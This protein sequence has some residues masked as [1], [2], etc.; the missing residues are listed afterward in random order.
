MTRKQTLTVVLRRPNKNVPWGISIA[1][2]S[3]LG[4]PLIVTRVSF[5]IFLYLYTVKKCQILSSL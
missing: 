5:M 4:T 3:D 2:G 1:G